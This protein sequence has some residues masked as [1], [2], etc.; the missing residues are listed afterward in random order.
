[1]TPEELKIGLSLIEKEFEI[2]INTDNL[3]KLE[4]ALSNEIIR[5]LLNSS[6]KLWN[7]L[8]RI[9]VSEKQVKALFN[10]GEPKTI[11]PAISKLIINRMM[12]KAKTRLAYRE[13]K[14]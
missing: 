14:I 5:L 13:G 4:A 10:S 11:A 6:E 3:E 12:Q 2:D 9:D 8:Y 7:I 1:M